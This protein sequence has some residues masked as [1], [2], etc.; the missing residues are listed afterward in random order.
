ME[1]FPGL[2]GSLP[3]TSMHSCPTFGYVKTNVKTTYH[4]SVA[5]VISS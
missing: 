1:L 4:I 5:G 3:D 2:L